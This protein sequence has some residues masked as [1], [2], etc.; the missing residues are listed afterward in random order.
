MAKLINGVELTAD[1]SVDHFA[2]AAQVAIE[3]IHMTASDQEPSAAVHARAPGTRR[4]D[5]VVGVAIVQL[6]RSRIELLDR[7]RR[8]PFVVQRQV[9]T[10]ILPRS[11][12][13]PRSPKAD[14][15]NDL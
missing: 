10:P 3:K 6:A 14:C 13:P 1:A 11:A 4:R 7:K 8:G 2:H 12:A 5:Q 9:D 15:P